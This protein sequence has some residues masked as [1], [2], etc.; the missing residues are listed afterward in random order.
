METPKEPTPI[1]I[2][3]RAPRRPPVYFWGD[4]RLGGPPKIV[5]PEKFASA[6]ASAR[7]YAK[8]RPGTGLRFAQRTNAQGV[9]EIW[10]I[11]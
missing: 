10:R 1:P 8:R 4:M 6:I 2:P 9:K 11:S 3:V 5:R 7:G